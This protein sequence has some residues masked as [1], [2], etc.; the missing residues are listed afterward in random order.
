MHRSGSAL[1][2]VSDEDLAH[3]QQAIE[4][5]TPFDSR[6]QQV[7]ESHLGEDERRARGHPI[8]H[9]RVSSDVDNR[10]VAELSRVGETSQLLLRR[11]EPER[12]VDPGSVSA[13]S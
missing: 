6:I 10:E 5:A 3:R 4:D 1:G 7:R 9:Q 8:I 2:A 12:S 11:L 13:T